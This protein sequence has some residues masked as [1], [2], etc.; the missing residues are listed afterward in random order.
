MNVVILLAFLTANMDAVVSTSSN[1]TI[2][3]IDV[4]S[5]GTYTCFVVE[6]DNYTT[7]DIH[8]AVLPY[9]LSTDPVTVAAQPET[10]ITL[11]CDVL[12]VLNN[13]MAITWTKD[14]SIIPD[15]TNTTLTLLDV[16]NAEVGVYQCA[17]RGTQG[18]LMTLAGMLDL[19]LHGGQSGH[20]NIQWGDYAYQL[21]IAIIMPYML[22][23]I[24]L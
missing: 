15:E 24:T 23:A 7:A 22:I 4:T 12:A 11:T 13:D 6:T 3:S 17:I 10:N 20:S 2:D 16:G 5:A 8:V 9:V 18:A 19:G 21:Y 14:N 1:Y